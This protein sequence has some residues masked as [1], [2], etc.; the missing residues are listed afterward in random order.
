MNKWKKF[1]FFE[2]EVLYEPGTRA[3][4]SAVKVGDPP[5]RM[6]A[7]LRPAGRAPRNGAHPCHALTISPPARTPQALD[8]TCAAAGPTNLIFGDAAGGVT[9]LDPAGPTRRFKPHDINVSCIAVSREHKVLVTVGDGVDPRDALTRAESR[10]IAADA[11]E[12]LRE[13]GSDTSYLE[14][15]G[16]VAVRGAR[17]RPRPRRALPLTPRRPPRASPPP[18]RPAY[19]SGSW[20]AWTTAGSRSA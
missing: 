5:S 15:E 20:I 13:A 2:K 11:R 1:R 8:L 17:A 16:A 14:S 18:L 10:I 19:A 4:H 6:R 3:P 7:T 12:R 9:F